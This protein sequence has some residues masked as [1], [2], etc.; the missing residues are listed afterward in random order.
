[1][2]VLNI[3]SILSYKRMV[4]NNL[5][6]GKLE[7]WNCSHSMSS[8]CQVKCLKLTDERGRVEAG[9]KRRWYH[10]GCFET[11]T[12][13]NQQST[14]STLALEDGSYDHG[15]A[16]HHRACNCRQNQA[17]PA[18]T[19]LS[20]FGSH[21]ETQQTHIFI[22]IQLSIVKLIFAPFLVVVILILFSKNFF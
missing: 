16:T 17:A 3:E 4:H 7:T 20:V 15:W 14:L 13:S 12:V 22:N 21:T 19:A 9:E 2:T 18:S 10:H 6:L 5:Q 8:V 1:M 11:L